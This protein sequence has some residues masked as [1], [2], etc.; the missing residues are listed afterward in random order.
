[1]S[2]NMEKINKV[3]EEIDKFAITSLPEDMDINDVAGIHDNE[4]HIIMTSL[5][6]TRS[7]TSQPKRRNR[8][9]KQSSCFSTW[10][11]VGDTIAPITIKIAARGFFLKF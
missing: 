9:K 8:R 6:H 10:H 2:G 4:K 7:V 1:M 5:V 3:Q 11:H